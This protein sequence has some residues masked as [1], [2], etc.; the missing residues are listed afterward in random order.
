[1]R[2]GV[3]RPTIERLVTYYRYLERLV[4]TGEQ[5][6]VSSTQLGNGV[7]VSAAQVRK[8]LSYF[9]EFGYKGVGYDVQNLK[10]CLERILGFNQS[11]PIILVGT[12]NIGRALVNYPGFKLMGLNI[13][14]I[15]DCSLDKIGNMVGNLTVRSNKEINRV[16][17]EKKI[18]LAIISVPAQ[19]AQPVAERLV[20]LGIK[21][22]WNFAPVSLKLPDDVIVYYEDLASSL[23][24]LTYHL[25]QDDQSIA[26]SSN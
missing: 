12:G 26:S 15:F 23:V 3:P 24:S 2:R 19:E 1:M 13:V 4:Q 8:D 14:E 10:N 11:W 6:I 9:G 7:G 18:K 5:E 20:N 16:V 25:A 17:T 21:A 22:I